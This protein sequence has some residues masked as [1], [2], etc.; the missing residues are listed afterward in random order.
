LSFILFKTNEVTALA[1]GGRENRYTRDVGCLRCD[2]CVFRKRFPAVVQVEPRVVSLL[3]VVDG[4][5][6]PAFGNP[7]AFVSTAADGVP[8]FGVPS[9]GDVATTTLPEPVTPTSVAAETLLETAAS[10]NK[11]GANGPVLGG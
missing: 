8:R 10:S 3:T 1:R 11:L 9:V 2:R 6:I 5:T 4:L 7:V